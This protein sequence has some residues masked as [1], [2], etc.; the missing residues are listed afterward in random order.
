MFC[1]NGA[2]CM[3]YHEVY[4]RNCGGN[5]YLDGGSDGTGPTT[6]RFDHLTNVGALA[7]ECKAPGPG[8]RIDKVDDAPDGYSFINAIFWGNA[9]G[10]DFVATCDTGCGKVRVNVS[11]SMMQT[12][13]REPGPEGHVRG[14]ESWRPPIRCSPIRRTGDFHLK[15]AAGRWTPAGYVK[16]AVN[17]PGARQRLSGRSERSKIPSAPASATSSAPTATAARRRMCAEC[18]GGLRSSVMSLFFC[19]SGIADT[20]RTNA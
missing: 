2:T 12:K 16:D 3:S 5:I 17:E 19:S 13:Y 8:V 1:D 7:V 20:A 6:A 9:P 10:V 14:R 15:S 11:Y 4:D 18:A